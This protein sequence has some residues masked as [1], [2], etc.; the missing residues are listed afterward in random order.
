MAT[1]SAKTF[2]PARH[3]SAA[4][5]GQSWTLTFTDASARSA[6][7]IW[8]LTRQG[9]Q[10]WTRLVR[11]EANGTFLKDQIAPWTITLT[12]IAAA[13]R[14]GLLPLNRQS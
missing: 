10:M 12:L 13:V 2:T 3:F 14:D 8:V 9:E 7:R 5:D 1:I 6:E 11:R 4:P